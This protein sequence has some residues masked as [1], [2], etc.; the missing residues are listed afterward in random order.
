MNVNILVCQHLI[1]VRNEWGCIVEVVDAER[2]LTEEEQL[3]IIMR[4]ENEQL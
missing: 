2:I 3:E 1:L 4:L